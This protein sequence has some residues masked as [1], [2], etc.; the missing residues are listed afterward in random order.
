MKK[1]ASEA[2]KLPEPITMDSNAIYM[3]DADWQ[4]G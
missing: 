2:L 1:E 3:T 4:D